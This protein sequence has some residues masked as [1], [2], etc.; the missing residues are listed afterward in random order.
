MNTVYDYKR[1]AILYVD[2]EEKSLK[3]FTLT[4]G[5]T[6]RVFTAN[7]AADG[8]RLL[9]DH[10]DEIGVVVTDQRMP[11]EQ[12]VQFLERARRLRPQ[13][14]RILATAYADIEA[15][16]AAVNSGAIYK[17][18]TKPWDV[19]SLETTLKRGLEFFMVQ[20]ERD[21]LLREK[22]S[23]LHRLLITDRVLSLG[24]MAA[25]LSHQLRHALEAVRHFVEI[26]PEDRSGEN[27]D[28]DQL[29]NPNFWQEFH[30]NVQQRLRLLL[31][32]LDDLATETGSS[33]RF[34]TEARV[35]AAIDEAIQT[36]GTE[37]A[38]RRIQVTNAVSPTLPA[39][40]VDP[41]RFQRL[42][43][44]LL[45]NEL[46]N[47][48]EGSAVRFEAVARPAA[49]GLPEEVVLVLSDNGNGI[50]ANAI[51][52]IFDP[53]LI[54]QEAPQEAGIYL[55]AC[56]FIVFHHGGRIDLARNDAGGLA[57][58]ITLPVRPQP[59]TP[60]DES[61]AFLIRTMSNERLWERLLAGT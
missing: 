8:Y 11:G 54:R 24:V 3:Y 5:D 25:G 31:G 43:T 36:L 47:L 44:L 12:G 39:L 2:D 9:E 38:Q 20:A 58:T 61:E 26:A 35:H 51:L 16:I 10:Q 49:D 19:P 17:Y 40:C 60:V 56:Y 30:R 48:P 23:T 41:R 33:F 14:I 55:M 42:F 45:R 37:L 53:F 57:I 46:C 18:V 28:L 7:N 6:F 52:S 27:L 4:M 34:D 15:A 50:P 1:F 32:L 13:I 21:L 22:L 59:F 29:R